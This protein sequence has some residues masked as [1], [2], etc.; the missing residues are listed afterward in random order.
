MRLTVSS[1]VQGMDWG[2]RGE[3]AE[4]PAAMDAAAAVIWEKN[5]GKGGE[6]IDGCARKSGRIWF[7]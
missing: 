1:W 4:A 3:E 5:L 7:M 2:F 6:A